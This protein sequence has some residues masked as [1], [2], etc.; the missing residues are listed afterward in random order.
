ML[1]EL[2]IYLL[3]PPIFIKSCYLSSSGG[4]LNP[5]VSL[6]VM[7]AGKLHPIPGTCYILMQIMGAVSGAGLVS[8]SVDLCTFVVS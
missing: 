2:Q 1:M 7:I 8:V 5:A 4:Y 3:L 6:A